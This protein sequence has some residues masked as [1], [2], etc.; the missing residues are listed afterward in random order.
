MHAVRIVLLAV[1]A[2]VLYGIAHDLV[3]AHLCVEYF[4]IGHPRVIDSERP[5]DLALVWG[6]LATWW[7]G[8]IAGLL[9][10]W[11][12]L[13]GPAPKR[14]AGSLVK[15]VLVCL[16]IMAAGALVAG[17]LGRIAASNGW[18]A[19]VSP[20]AERVPAEKH[21]AYL[22]NLWAHLASYWIGGL[23]MLGLALRVRRARRSVQEPV[24]R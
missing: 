2:A 22:G 4:T 9:L 17:V 10:A 14:T 3:T 23:A 12:A 13:Q 11:A 24:S 5:V 16:G 7:M 18:V 19:L 15:P 1:A 20:L 21:V 8:V 6:V